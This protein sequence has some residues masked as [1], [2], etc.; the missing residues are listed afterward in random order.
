M[1]VA[2]QSRPLGPVA[3][4][5]RRF[6]LATQDGPLR[7]VWRLSYAAVARAYVAYLRRGHRGSA[8][9]LIGGVGSRD[10]V[11]GN[12]DV[13][14]VVVLPGDPDIETLTRVRERWKNLVERVPAARL[15]LDDPQVYSEALLRR[16]GDS[17]LTLGLDES[18]EPLGAPGWVGPVHRL[19][20]RPGLEGPSA[21]WRRVAGPDLRPP[22]PRR[23]RQ[24]QRIAAWLELQRWWREAFPLCALPGHPLAADV[25]VKMVAEP[26][27]VW[28]WLVH[29]ERP[30]GRAAAIQ[31]AAERIPA[32]ATALRRIAELRERPHASGP[33]PVAEAL[34]LLIVLSEA[35][36]G[37]I[38]EETAGAELVD[39]QLDGAKDPLVL[40][41]G[42]LGAHPG[43][44]PA[45]AALVGEVSELLPLCDWPAL[46]APEV[47]DGAVA[48]LAADAGDPAVLGAAARLGM[49]GAYPVMRCGALIVMP[50]AGWTRALLRA[51]S[52]PLTDPVTFAL[53]SG[54]TVAR[55]PEL[56]GWA[57][58]DW[59]ARAVAE[60]RARREQQLASGGGVAL[61]HAIT[62]ARATLFLES[63][64]AGQPRLALNVAAT[65][66]ALS[67]RGV[68]EGLLEEAARAHSEFA[69]DGTEP[70]QRVIDALLRHAGADYL[71]PAARR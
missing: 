14:P 16:G 20:V 55:F 40:P 71:R 56:R 35:I 37:A 64:E 33:A 47:P 13:D 1:P 45:D 70:E 29:G 5:L 28:L 66:R 49:S 31:R 36:A 61:G 51:P 65:L 15:M 32:E 9:Y 11:Y 22:P 17:M 53:L 38:A 44:D 4:T 18:E 63:T 58:R 42:G 50:S 8:G 10:A 69:A 43:R 26:A 68:P 27:R 46:V 41:K 3:R 34:R 12:S 59:A 6:V 54:E 21:R 25:C 52:S 39:V 60:H 48:P 23:D 2:E 7:I 19:L 30:G 62:E 67:D 57:A 24:D